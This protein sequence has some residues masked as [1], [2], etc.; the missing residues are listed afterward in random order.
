MRIPRAPL[1]R[2]V[3][4]LSRIRLAARLESGLTAWRKRLNCW[5]VQ[6]DQ[7]PKLYSVDLSETPRCTTPCNLGLCSDC[8]PD[9]TGRPKLTIVKDW[10]GGP[11]RYLG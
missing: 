4:L 1:G 10:L 3:F 2:T 7:P 9:G 11:V 8:D 6:L 5:L